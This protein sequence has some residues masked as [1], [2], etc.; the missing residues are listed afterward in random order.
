MFNFL[1]EIFKPNIF[2][3]LGLHEYYLFFDF[4]KEHYIVLTIPPEQTVQDLYNLNHNSIIEYILNY[5]SN[6]S[7]NSSEFKFIVISE[8]NPYTRIKL[9]DSDV[10]TK[11]LKSKIHFLYYL[12]LNMKEKDYDN[13]LKPQYMIGNILNKKTDLIRKGELWK[14]SFKKNKFDKR[15]L[16]LD[17]EKI[18]IKKLE[19]N[20]V[21][22]IP[23]NDIYSV[24]TEITDGNIVLKQISKL[25]FEIKTINN[26][27][28]YFSGKSISDIESWIKSIKACLKVSN[29]NK[30]FFILE[31]MN[32]H[33]NM[34]I[35]T[36][37]IKSI[38][39]IFSLNSIFSFQS[40]TN[41]FLSFVNLKEKTK[42][43]QN[44]SSSSSSTLI[45]TINKEIYKQAEVFDN[46]NQSLYKNRNDVKYSTYSLNKNKNEM[47][48]KRSNSFQELNSSNKKIILNNKLILNQIE[49]SFKTPKSIVKTYDFSSK[50]EVESA[51]ELI[52]LINDFKVTCAFLVKRQKLEKK[53]HIANSYL[54]MNSN[55]NKSL[56]SCSTNNDMNLID[57]IN[58]CISKFENLIYSDEYLRIFSILEKENS[59]KSSLMKISHLK[60]IISTN[61]T[62]KSSVISFIKIGLFDEIQSF[63]IQKYFD[64]KYKSF[65]SEI[66]S[67]CIFKTSPLIINL[68]FNAQLIKK[69][70]NSNVV[71][72]KVFNILVNQYLK[73]FVKENFLGLDKIYSINE[74]EY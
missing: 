23:F 21:H 25:G 33:L 43:N 65:L 31:K 59:L 29:D 63:L 32:H 14:F 4:K 46:D 68:T 58:I 17:K 49:I 27:S 9:K 11:Y 37:E 3:Q 61:H 72:S 66:I 8:N 51:I 24:S 67:N 47:N 41:I 36:S 28:F 13:S 7:I 56:S 1:K 30:K 2:P 62:D 74:E 54:G 15:G 50:N 42:P 26:E 64:T 57:I 71:I 5:Y 44:L 34:N 40:L 53:S 45:D 60:S 18:L 70:T 22:V 38:N 48:Q 35:Y 20:E 73:D 10:V 52:N 16:T 69:K 39:S 55:I 19:G 12:N 6:H